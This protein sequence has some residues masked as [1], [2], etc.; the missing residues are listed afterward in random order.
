MSQSRATASETQNCADLAHE[1]TKDY[2][3]VENRLVKMKRLNTKKTRQ[4]NSLSLM[5]KLF[6]W[7]KQVYFLKFLFFGPRIKEKCR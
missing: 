2:E 6:L 7:K 3:I 4:I 1:G 5:Q